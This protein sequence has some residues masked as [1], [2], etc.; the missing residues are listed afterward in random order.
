[1]SK[2]FID[3]NQQQN[4]NN[5]QSE[6]TQAKVDPVAQLKWINSQQ[7]DQGW[8]IPTQMFAQDEEEEPV[9]GKAEDEELLQMQQL[10]DTT[11]QNGITYYRTRALAEAAVDVHVSPSSCFVWNEGPSNYKWR[12]VPGT[13]CAHWVAHELGIT[14]NPGCFDGNAIRV[15]QVTSGKTEY[16]LT[17]AQVGDIWTNTGGTHTG[18]V[19]SVTTTNKI[20]TSVSVEHCSSAQGGVVTSTF[21][22]GRFYR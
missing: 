20:I 3:R 6:T 5:N 2:A 21:T 22:T 4:S 16:A 7:V 12:V 14:G 1:M 18:I 10:P 19:R 11:T 17:N 13:G 9:Q 15:S 8:G